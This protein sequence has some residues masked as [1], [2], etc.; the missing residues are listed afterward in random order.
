MNVQLKQRQLLTSPPIIYLHG[1]I[2]QLYVISEII[3][4]WYL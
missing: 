1:N 4:D 2:F 3:K